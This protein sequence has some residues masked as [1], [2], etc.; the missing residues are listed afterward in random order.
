MESWSAQKTLLIIWLIM[1]NVMSLW[2]YGIDKYRSKKK[3]WRIPES[4][5]LMSAAAGGAFGAYLGMIL[6]RHKTQHTH[7]IILVP[8]CVV[9]WTCLSLWLL[10]FAEI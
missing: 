9:L 10:F 7:F 2:M 4:A 1:I 5:L 6:F 3:K 8:L